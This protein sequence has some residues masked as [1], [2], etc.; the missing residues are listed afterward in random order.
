MAEVL[1]GVWAVGVSFKAVVIRLSTRTPVSTS[2]VP[3]II[4]Q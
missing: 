4:I 1:L 2:N 3:L